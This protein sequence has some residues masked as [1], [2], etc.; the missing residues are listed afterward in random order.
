MKYILITD[1]HLGRNN[2]NKHE[3]DQTLTLFNHI[4][5]IANDN[6]ITN[7]IHL[8]DFFD[9]RKYL[10]LNTIH[11]AKLISET[12]KDLTCYF[13]LGNHDI[14]N[15]NQLEPY[16]SV[17]FD[18]YFNINVITK[19][20]QLDNILLTPWFFSKSDL[21]SDCDY[22]MGH[23][24]M[25]GPIINKSGTI[26][27]GHSLNIS[28]FSDFKQVFSGHYH[29]PGEYNNIK[30]LG[31]PY[32]QDFNDSGD[33]GYY[34]FDSDNGELEFI[35][36]QT[37]EYKIIDAESNFTEIDIKNNIIRLEFHNNIGDIEIL[38]K[39]S[40]IESYK[41]LKYKTKFLFTTDMTEEDIDLD[42]GSI[43]NNKDI[44]KEY[45]NKSE[46]KLDKDRL[47]NIIKELD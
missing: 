6:N 46:I 24:D 13:I 36:Y 20:T 25:N 42:V 41:P 38:N 40:L 5:Q 12:L 27:E 14:L 15:K 28:D 47:L 4:I 10:T 44:L 26:S 11:Y 8:G 23:F 33:R 43:V 17:I 1:T 30:Y 37:N 7:L 22:C 45:I 34:I 32:H 21:N 18:N 3:L 31:S 19:T 39:T 9:N 2:S 16:S 35:K 29:T